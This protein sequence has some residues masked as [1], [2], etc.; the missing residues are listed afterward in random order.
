MQADVL[1]IDDRELLCTSLA[2]SFEERGHPAVYAQN[3]RDALRILLTYDIGVVVLD[4]KLGA[5]NGLDVLADILKLKKEIPVIMITGHGTIHMAV[6]ALKTG[7]ID[8]I[9]KPVPFP[10]LYEVFE[11]ALSLKRVG[12]SIRRDTRGP[13]ETRR[14]RFIT[15]DNQMVQI[16]I[17]ASSLAQSDLP[18][19]I[20]GE[21]GTGKELVAEFIH[22]SSPRADARI[23]KINCSAFPESLL[24]NELFGHEP[25]AFTD[26]RDR[27]RGV[28]EQADTGTLFLDEVGDMPLHLQPRVLRVLQS[29][30]FRR[31]GGE[32]DIR[33]DVRFVAATNRTLEELIAEKVFREDLYYRLNAARISLPPLRERVGDIPLLACHFLDRSNTLTGRDISLSDEVFDVLQAYRWPGNVRELQNA[34]LYSAAVTTSDTIGIDCLPAHMRTDQIHGSGPIDPSLEASERR[35]IERALRET[36]YNKKRAAEI[37]NISRATLYKKIRKYE[38]PIPR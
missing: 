20:E 30:E 37:L 10:R 24:D 7:A 17:D 8:F 18:I 14:D 29:G 6:E 32:S 11:K 22:A 21:S 19:L 12:D 31:L 27:Y 28:F 15:A 4:V 36:R 35:T 5:E 23:V 34:V 13:G 38:I 1:I 2:T 33:V 25:G 3:R 16:L 26:A 9:E